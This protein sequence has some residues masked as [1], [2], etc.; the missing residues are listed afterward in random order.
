MSR[1][2]PLILGDE[3]E[4]AVRDGRTCGLRACRK[5]HNGDADQ[6]PEKI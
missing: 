1:R 3:L 5:K 4:S 2:D 6:C